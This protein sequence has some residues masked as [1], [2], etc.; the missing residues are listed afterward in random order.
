MQTK[1]ELWVGGS[2]P[3]LRWRDSTHGEKATARIG[4]SDLITGSTMK[5]IRID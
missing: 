2:A 3:V 4:G 1:S 5:D